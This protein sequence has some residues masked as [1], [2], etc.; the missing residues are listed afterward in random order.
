MRRRI[1]GV[2]IFLFTHQMAE[3]RGLLLARSCKTVSL[4]LRVTGISSAVPCVLTVELLVSSPV[5]MFMGFLVLPWK[6]TVFPVF[7]MFVSSAA[8][9][10]SSFS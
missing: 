2:D 1:L 9:K 6:P 3:L 8:G 7:P 5:G 10:V 4:C